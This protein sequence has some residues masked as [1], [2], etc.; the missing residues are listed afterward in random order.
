MMK[1]RINYVGRAS[2]QKFFTIGTEEGFEI[3]ANNTGSDDVERKSKYSK[4]SETFN[5]SYN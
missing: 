3:L 1:N 4:L 5:I 2:N